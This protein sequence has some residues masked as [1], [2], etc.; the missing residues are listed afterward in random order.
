MRANAVSGFTFLKKLLNKVR[1]FLLF[2]KIWKVERLAKLSGGVAV[3]NIGATTEIRS[4]RFNLCFDLIYTSGNIF[5]LSLTTNNRCVV[6]VFNKNI[7]GLLDNL[8]LIIVNNGSAFVQNI[9]E[10]NLMND[11]ACKILPFLFD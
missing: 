7:V 2:R 9:V 4:C 10:K 6:F 8:R 5:F 3:L 1:S 11:G